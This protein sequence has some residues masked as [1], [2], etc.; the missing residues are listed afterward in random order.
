MNTEY[1]P[2]Q[3]IKDLYNADKLPE[4][5]KQVRTQGDWVFIS[6]PNNTTRRIRPYHHNKLL[7]GTCEAGEGMQE[8]AQVHLD[9][10]NINFLENNYENETDATN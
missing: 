7:S 4:G 8:I 3:K 2:T 1:I 6:T 9:H 10:D 5:Y